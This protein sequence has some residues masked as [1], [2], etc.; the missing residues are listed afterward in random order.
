MGNPH[1][2]PRCRAASRE[3]AGMR[4]RGRS[5]PRTRAIALGWAR[6]HASGFGCAKAREGGGSAAARPTTP[7]LGPSSSFVTTSTRCVVHIQSARRRNRGRRRCSQ[8]PIAACVAAS[9]LIPCR[10]RRGHL[11]PPPPRRPTALVASAAP[12]S[13]SLLQHAARVQGRERHS[14]L[15]STPFSLSSSHQSCRLRSRRH[16]PRSRPHSLAPWLADIPAEAVPDLHSRA[17]APRVFFL[18]PVLIL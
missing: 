9:V 13:H 10:H 5:R 8:H 6:T 1:A 18:R 4:L 11:G 15:R 16:A 14:P 7:P 2:A 12:G 3:D 17:F